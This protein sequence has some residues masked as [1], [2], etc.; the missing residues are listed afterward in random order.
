MFYYT[1]VKAIMI[2]FYY[3]SQKE[4]QLRPACSTIN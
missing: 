4:N 1:I 2:Y 3:L